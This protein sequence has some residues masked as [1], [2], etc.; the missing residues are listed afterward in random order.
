MVN[1]GPLA[2]EIGLPVW[3]TQQIST[4]SRVGFVT[5]PTSLNGRQPNFVLCLAVTMAGT[6]SILF[7]GLLPPKGIL[8]GADFT[9]L[10]SLALS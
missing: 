8:P 9:L 7:L 2:T 5:A 4:V 3:G 1:F 10:L 6:L